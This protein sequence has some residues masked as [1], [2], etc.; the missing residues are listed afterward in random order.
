ML[1][2]A[3]FKKLL[4][5]EIQNEMNLLEVIRATNIEQHKEVVQSKPFMSFVKNKEALHHL[6]SFL[7]TIKMEEASTGSD[8]GLDKY[9]LT[10]DRL[11]GEAL[12]EK[13]DKILDEKQLQSENFR[14][15]AS[16]R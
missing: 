2:P 12:S 3:N 7:M 11:L 5:E 1:K 9:E 10:I 6:N 8:I 13:K 15:I 14:Y 4:L 16:Q